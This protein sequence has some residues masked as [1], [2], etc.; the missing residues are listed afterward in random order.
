MLDHL[1]P[2]HVLYLDIETVPLAKSLDSMPER[3][4]EQ[5]TKKA[6]NI[7]SEDDSPES[8]FLPNLE[9]LSAFRPGPYTGIVKANKGFTALNHFM[10][11][12]SGNC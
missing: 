4:Q 11:M 6:A 9:K 12:M 5:W 8:L 10:A 7:G 3:L 2:E 1:K